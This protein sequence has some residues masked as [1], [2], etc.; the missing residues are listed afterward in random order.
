MIFHHFTRTDFSSDSVVYPDVSTLEPLKREILASHDCDMHLVVATETEHARASLWWTHVPQMEGRRPGTIGHFAATG[1]IAAA[2]VL[3]EASR[4]LRQA[5]CTCA[6]G[7]M[8]GTTWRKYRFV[9]DLRGERDSAEPPFML[10]P[11][12]P[13]DY[14]KWFM[15]NGFAPLAQYSS[16]LVTDLEREDPRADRARARLAAGGIEI[17]AMDPARF[18]ADLEAVYHLSCQSFTQQYL[19]TPIDLPHFLALY[20]PLRARMV[21]EMVLLAWQGATLVGYL[22][23]IPDLTQAQRGLQVNTAIIKT[24][25]ILPARAFAG[26]GAVLVNEFHRRARAMGMTRCIHALAHEGN[27]RS[28]NISSF[29]GERMRGYT[30]YIKDL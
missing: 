12:N 7:P 21:A 28:Q 10:E 13:D 9:T 4:L 6:V 26:L 29:F 11:Q 14:P 23:G 8:D 24:L 20:Q 25:A 27:A 19:Y 30:L 3:D 16:T 5:G 18:D 22:F 15:Q 2:A 1:P 17:R